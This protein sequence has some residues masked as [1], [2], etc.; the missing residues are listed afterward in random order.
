MNKQDQIAKSDNSNASAHS[1]SKAIDDILKYIPEDKRGKVTQL[2][3][4]QQQTTFQGPLPPPEVLRDYQNIMPGSPDRLLKLVEKEQEQVHSKE[5]KIIKN[6]IRQ[7]WAGMIIGAVLITLFFI[8]AIWLAMSHH[9][10]VAGIVFSTT[11]ISVATIFVLHRRS[12]KN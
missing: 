2:I 3:I 11:I 10:T 9:D 7:N 12:D 5:N 8:G 1:N 6:Q 4:R